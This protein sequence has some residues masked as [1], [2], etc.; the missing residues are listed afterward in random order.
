MVLV[1]VVRVVEAVDEAG[2]I[3]AVV[4]LAK[5]PLDTEVIVEFVTGVTSVAVMGLWAAEVSTAEVTLVLLVV[6]LS[7][8]VAVVGI[9]VML[10]ELV[11]L[12]TSP[13]VTM[14]DVVLEISV[15]GWLL[16]EELVVLQTVTIWVV[17]LDISAVDWLELVVL[18]TVTRFVVLDISVA[19]KLEFEETVLFPV[20]EGVAVLNIFV[21]D[22]LV[23]FTV[24]L[25]VELAELT[26]SVV[27]WLLFEEEVVLPVAFMAVVIWD[28]S[29]V[30]WLL[31]EEL[32]LFSV[33][34]VELADVGVFV[35]GGLL[36]GLLVVITVATVVVLYVTKL[37]ICV[38]G[39]LFS[40]E[41]EE[42]DVF[43]MV[44]ADVSVAVVTV[45]LVT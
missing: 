40:E 36:F 12:L 2:G 7:T 22:W 29:D 26:I 35:V 25:I 4:K 43:V 9:S 27:N 31:T 3:P 18:P 24:L 37:C 42:P 16:L 20:T 15:V 38:V 19:D 34:N 44:G 11:A 10:D 13:V 39:V 30:A 33:V 6:L 23:V 21:V 32:V 28:I 45:V 5:D 14:A 8:I 1:V 41:I 17:P